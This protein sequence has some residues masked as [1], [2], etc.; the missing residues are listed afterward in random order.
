MLVLFDNHTSST[1]RRCEALIR[2]HA[3]AIM[4]SSE[5]LKFRTRR[6][7]EPD[8]LK[9]LRELY[10]KGFGPQETARALGRPKRSVQFYFDRWRHGAI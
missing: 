1:M 5:P 8:E 10:E 2:K 6:L 7:W 9:R 4:A 3:P